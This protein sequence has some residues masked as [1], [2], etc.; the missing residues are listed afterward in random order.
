M[1]DKKRRTQISLVLSAFIGMTVI[2]AGLQLIYFNTMSVFSGIKHPL[3]RVFTVDIKYLHPDFNEE[4]ITRE[5]FQKLARFEGIEELALMAKS[6]GKVHYGGMSYNADALGVTSSF[7]EFESMAVLKGRRFNKYDELDKKSVA[8]LPE[9]FAFKIFRSTNVIGEHI[10]VNGFKLEIVGIIKSKKGLV[11]YFA[12]SDTEEIYVPITVA[13]AI[14]KEIKGVKLWVLSSNGANLQFTKSQV[15]SL[16]KGSYRKPLYDIRDYNELKDKTIQPVI[17]VMLFLAAVILI[18]RIVRFK[19][20]LTSNASLVFFIIIVAFGVFAVNTLIHDIFIPE[21]YIPENLIDIEAYEEILEDKIIE[22]NSPLGY[23]RKGIDMYANKVFELNLYILVL[24]ILAGGYF[25]LNAR[26]ICRYTGF[27]K[28]LLHP[29]FA[30]IA[31]SFILTLL[32]AFYFKYRFTFEW[33]WE[34]ILIGLAVIP[35]LGDYIDFIESKS[36]EETKNI[37]IIV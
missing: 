35:I 3:D 21:K 5:H 23:E 14:D 2:F 15:E 13:E 31:A 6:Y 10:E 1:N 32:Y 8:I 12:N 22:T 25:S 29:A 7:W 34:I 27:Y 11:S 4:Y 9:D 33:R 18:R 24:T 30:G 17:W 28:L 16:I 20:Y 36:V 19:C 26:W 37:E